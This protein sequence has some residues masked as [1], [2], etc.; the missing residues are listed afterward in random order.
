MQRPIHVNEG[1]VPTAVDML[2]T[3]VIPI[4]GLSK[5]AK[6]SLA[7]G[8]RDTILCAGGDGKGAC[9]GDSGGPLV[10][11][12]TG[13]LI[14]L[15]SW[16]INDAGRQFCNLAPAVFTRVGSYMSFIR[17]NLGGSPCKA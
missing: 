12:V 1:W 15:A 2:S 8:N 4:H 3:A 13:Q 14:G 6:Y 11:Q 17:E 9:R 7:V 10:D 16:T 5:C